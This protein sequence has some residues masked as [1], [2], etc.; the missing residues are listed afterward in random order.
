[1][2]SAFD[3]AR[4][5]ALG[6]DWCNAARGFMFALGCIQSQTCHTGNCPTGV[7]TQDPQREK[8]LVVVTKADRVFHF[9]SRLLRH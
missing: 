7:A 1:M 8:A 5:L 4:M 3:I 6:A 9:H 2:V